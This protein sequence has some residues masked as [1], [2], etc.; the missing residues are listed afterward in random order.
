MTDLRLLPWPEVAARAA[1]PTTRVICTPRAAHLFKNPATE[2]TGSYPLTPRSLDQDVRNPDTI[3]TVIV[4]GGGSLIDHVKRVWRT[5]YPAARELIA[6]PTIWG[7]GAEASPVAVW[8]ED[9]KKRFALDESLRPTFVSFNPGFAVT[10]SPERARDACGD[11]WSHAIEGFLSPLSDDA[12]RG[13][14]AALIARLLELPI[15]ADARWFEPGAEAAVLQA[16][17]SVGLVHGLA[18]VLEPVLARPDLGQADP[19]VAELD[20]RNLSPSRPGFGHDQRIA[21]LDHRNLS[22]SRPDFGHARLCALL[23]GPV[24]RWNAATSPKWGEL[25]AAHGLDRERIEAIVESLGDG[26]GRRELVPAI[27]ANWRTVLRD[28]CTRT[29]SALVRPDSLAGV[30]AAIGG[31]K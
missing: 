17:A 22:P 23:L 15:A 2:G 10:V 30:V 20:P 6:V 31:G 18:H 27:E 3:D 24:L 19:A 13:Q 4:A 29:N 8:T 1:L 25:C 21:G 14:F 7:S 11:V 5:E 26:E 28:P 12:L 16:R 9:G